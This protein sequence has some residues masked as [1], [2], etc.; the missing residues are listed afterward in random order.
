MPLC[1][2]KIIEQDK[3]ES[4][5]RGHRKIESGSTAMWKNIIPL[6]W[7]SWL[8]CRALT[9]SVLRKLSTEWQKWLEEKILA[10]DC[11]QFCWLRAGEMR[12]HLLG[13]FQ[14][15][16]LTLAFEEPHFTTWNWIQEQFKN[17]K[18]KNPTNK[19]LAAFKRLS[20][21][22]FSAALMFWFTL[23]A[24]IDLLNTGFPSSG[25]QHVAKT[26]YLCFEECET[27]HNH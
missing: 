27:T 26:H 14:E 12:F 16:K 7:R 8:V 22:W 5:M 18:Q 23:T 24:R 15:T 25:G 11:G 9:K 1:C 4:N 13:R 2:W 19:T 21:F 3:I 17:K 10:A 6:L 20:A